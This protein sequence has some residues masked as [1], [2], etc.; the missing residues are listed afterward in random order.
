MGESIALLKWTFWEY[1]NNVQ[2]RSRQSLMQ[3]RAPS[4]SSEEDSEQERQNGHREGHSDSS[5][6]ADTT[7][8]SA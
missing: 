6:K 3:S 8:H 5:Q 2:M 1:I 4:P 7:M